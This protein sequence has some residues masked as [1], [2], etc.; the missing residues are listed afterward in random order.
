MMKRAAALFLLAFLGFTA[1]VHAQS[2]CTAP[3]MVCVAAGQVFPIS[4]FETTASAV[5]IAPGLLVTNRHAVADNRHA[6][7]FLPDKSQILA[8][9]VPTRYGG[10]L[11]LLRAPDFGAFGPIGIATAGTDDALYTIGAD[12]GRGRIRV[13]RPGRIVLAPSPG[14]PL[15]RLHH[16][17]PSQPGNSGGALVNGDG[18]LV[19]IVT[20]GGAGR[21]EAVPASE[22]AKLQALS[23]PEHLMES[24]R[25]GVAV[26][27]CAEAMDRANATNQR[28][29]ES[30]VDFLMAQ[31]TTS[32][33][34]QNMDLAGQTLGRQ[35][36]FEQSVTMFERALDQDPN[37]I[38]SRLALAITLH[39]ARRYEDEVVHLKRLI[40]V[41]PGDPQV[42]RLAI[43]AGKWSG[44]EAFAEYAFALLEAHHPAL[45]GRAKQFMN[46][47]PPPAPAPQ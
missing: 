19:A 25:I 4:S 27:K 39:L 45:A 36:Y 24:D 2:G 11:I 13:Y 16:T 26:K 7:V 14:K 43:Q 20:S 34:R 32:N 31:C 21:Y 42:L 23:G 44:D 33:N 35:R 8:D 46:L 30:H 3:A 10:D 12:I 38:N 17:A 22:I 28:L 41:I 9:V 5:L 15:A 29:G 37:A 18:K 47:P 1:P 6:Q 40:E